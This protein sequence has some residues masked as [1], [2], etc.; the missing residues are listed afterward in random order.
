[1]FEKI[2]SNGLLNLWPKIK[3]IPFNSHGVRIDLTKYPIASKNED[4]HDILTYL[5]LIATHR[6][7]FDNAVKSLLAC[8]DVRCVLL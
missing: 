3:N 7:N 5:K 6:V 1:M 8:S 2:D 4:V